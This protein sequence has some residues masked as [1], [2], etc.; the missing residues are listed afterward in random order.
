MASTTA[1]L[2]SVRRIDSSE[3]DSIES[4]VKRQTN[5]SLFESIHKPEKM[6]NMADIAFGGNT[7]AVAVNAALQTIPPGFFLYSALGNYLG[8]AFTDRT[9]QC[10]VRDV[11]STKTFATR[12]VE[13]SQVQKDGKRRLCLFLSADFQA[14]EPATLLTYSRPP[15]M[16]YSTVEDS[17]TIEENRQDSLKRGIVS[18]ETVALHKDLFG[19]CERF[20]HRR[21]CPEGFITQNLTGLAKKGTPTTQ[22]HLPLPSRS[23]GD[24]FKSKHPLKTPAEHTA[25]LAFVMDMG[26]LALT[27]RS[28]DEVR[29]QASLEFA[30]RVFTNG[31]DLNGW[32]LRELSTV[33]GGNGRIYG[34]A[35]VWD[36]RGKMLCNMTQQCLLRPK[37]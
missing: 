1:E 10:A 34:E 30:L 2:V 24:Y 12:H 16:A 20:I 29:S 32:C 25:A 35:Q 13:L 36:G 23:S 27:G 17:P 4:L 31:L 14:A 18:E 19:F 33:A 8:P 21:P 37:L 11:R 3:F 28:M 22:D 15:M 9:L 6:G 5:P 26:M 7:L